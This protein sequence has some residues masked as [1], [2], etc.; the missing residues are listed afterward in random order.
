MGMPI[1]G[2]S[3]LEDEASVEEVRRAYEEF[4]KLIEASL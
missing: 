3:T 4:R 1:G 2:I